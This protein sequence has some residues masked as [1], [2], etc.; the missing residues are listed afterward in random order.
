MIN[1][2]FADDTEI[3][4]AFE[5]HFNDELKLYKTICIVNL[6]EQSGKEKLIFDAYGNHVVKYDNDKLIYVTF[7]F[8]EYW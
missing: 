5:K 1:F 7:D 6:V 8:H 4:L 3:Q 2:D